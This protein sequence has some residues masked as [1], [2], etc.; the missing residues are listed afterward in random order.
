MLTYEEMVQECIA[1]FERND[2][3]MSI[4]S[5][6]EL[7]QI[8][9]FIEPRF[10]PYV[11]GYLNDR[12]IC[13]MTDSQSFYFVELRYIAAYALATLKNEPVYLPD[14]IS[15]KGGDPKLRAA[16]EEAG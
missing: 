5:Y 12:R 14:V 3:P 10:L 8:P 6:L 4:M 15:F 1:E 16:F 2:N 13:W 7:I 11:E 9:D